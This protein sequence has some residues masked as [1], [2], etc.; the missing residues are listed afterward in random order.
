MST[1]HPTTRATGNLVPLESGLR[2]CVA[3][4]RK[5]RPVNAER[6]DSRWAGTIRAGAHGRCVTCYSHIRPA[7]RTALERTES[8]DSAT[9]NVLRMWP[10]RWTPNNWLTLEEQLDAV[11]AQTDPEIF[12]PGKGGSTREARGVCSDCPIRTRCL[13]VAL[14]DP[15][16]VGVWGGTSER[17]RRKLRAAARAE[18]AA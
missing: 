17:E 6:D 8:G 7:Q 10:A 4:G 5:L 14:A 16:L 1:A 9:P 3:C 11:C 18:A 12:F 15:T 13:E 2:G